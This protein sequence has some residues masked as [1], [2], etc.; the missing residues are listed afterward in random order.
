MATHLY[1]L[2]RVYEGLR[3]AQ[4][5]GDERAIH[6]GLEVALGVE[7]PAPGP[8]DPD[9][10]AVTD[11]TYRGFKPAELAMLAADRKPVVK[12]EDI[13]IATAKRFVQRYSDSYRLVLS[14]AYRK[15]YLLLRSRPCKP[16]D[17]RAL[18]CIYASRDDTGARLLD[19]EQRHRDD[20]RGCGGLLG[21]PTCCI[22]AFVADFERSRADQDTLN[23]DACRRILASAPPGADH[24][25]LDPFADRELLGFYPCSLNC[26]AAIDFARRNAAALAASSPDAIGPARTTLGRPILFW[27][28]PFFIRL[29]GELRGDR[30]HYDDARINLF[31]DREVA[32]LQAAFGR[33]VLP[34]L[35]RGDSLRT[36]GDALVILSGDREVLRLAGVPQQGPAVGAF[37]RWPPKFF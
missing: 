14:P 24:P 8:W 31:A 9:R 37:D 22:D 12:L 25:G 20:I 16:D 5:R 19:L 2:A 27:R 6:A 17:R 23:D 30:L 34:L 15:D 28:L 13:P 11:L 35:R 36:E 18:V 33:R 4:R 3:H 10:D 29:R 1:Q 32:G 26:A 7:L 21:F